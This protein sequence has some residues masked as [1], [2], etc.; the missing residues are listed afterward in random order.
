MKS[1]LI[2]LL[3]LVLVACQ[4]NTQDNVELKTQKD[5]VSYAIGTD[6]GK[7]LKEQ[8]IE[9]NAA[10]LVRGISEA[11]AGGKKTL[12]DQQ[13]QECM[14]QFQ[15]DLAA[16]AHEKAMALGEKNKTEGESFLTQN[17]SKE[18]V[19]TTASG[20]QYTVITMGTGPKPK[21][22]QTVTLNYKGTLIDGTEFDNTYTRGQPI[23]FGVA[24]MPKGWVEGLQLMPVGSKFTFYVPSELAYG[25]AGAGGA[26]PP[27]A[28]LILE[29]E[30]LAVK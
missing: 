6:I 19:K 7:N 10:A 30:L 8:Q 5:T 27:N 12:T 29:V 16:K 25:P 4:S 26:I 14:G 13:I 9:I 22:E 18:G 28:T 20:L 17:K 1:L 21:P 24:A 11:I 2:T 15:K 3:G 23:T